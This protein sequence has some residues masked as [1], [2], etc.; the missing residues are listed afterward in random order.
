MQ[1]ISLKVW[2]VDKRFYENICTRKVKK[3]YINFCKI[4]IFKYYIHIH[5]SLE[6]TF[7]LLLL[8]SY[9]KKWQLTA[10]N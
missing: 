6:L 1:F 9:K 5:I 2:S 10:N 7:P 8:K 4:N 3:N